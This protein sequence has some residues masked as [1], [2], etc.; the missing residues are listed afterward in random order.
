LSFVDILGVHHLFEDMADNI[1]KTALVLFG[2][3]GL[4]QSLNY[5]ADSGAILV[6]PVLEVF[7]KVLEFVPV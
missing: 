2:D 5:V 6:F 7:V 1:L 4:K 3:L